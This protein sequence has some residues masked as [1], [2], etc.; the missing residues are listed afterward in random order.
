ME[1]LYANIPVRHLDLT[2]NIKS[3]YMKLIS[4]ITE[5]AIISTSIR[6][7][8]YNQT[9]LKPKESILNSGNSD[10]ILE[11][12]KRVLGQKEANSLM[13]FNCEIKEDLKIAGF[14]L[15][16]IN[17]GSVNETAWLKKNITFFYVNK[18]PIDPNKKIMYLFGEFYRQYNNNSK[19]IA[20]LNFIIDS[21]AVDNNLSP[22]KRE[23]C[24]ENEKE[25]IEM[26][27]KRLYESHEINKAFPKTINTQEIDFSHNKNRTKKKTEEENNIANIQ[28]NREESD[29]ITKRIKSTYDEK[30]ITFKK[31]NLNENYSESRVANSFTM[32][33]Y[34]SNVPTNIKSETK[35]ISEANKRFQIRTFEP[36]K[37]L[38]SISGKDIDDD[39]ARNF[40]NEGSMIK[41]KVT[42][43][44]PEKS[45]IFNAN[46]NKKIEIPIYRIG[47]PPEK[48]SN[49]IIINS[50]IEVNNKFETPQNAIIIDKGFKSTADNKF[51]LIEEN[52]EEIENISNPLTN[53]S[54]N[55]PNFEKTFQNFDEEKNFNT[56]PNF[57]KKEF[58]NFEIIGQFNLGFIITYLPQKR[59]IFIIDQHASDEKRNYE[60]MIKSY[61][62]ENQLLFN[63]IVIS[64]L[65]DLERNTIKEN[66]EI[67]FKNGFN[68]NFTDKNEQVIIKTLPCFKNIQFDLNDFHEILSHLTNNADDSFFRPN[69]FK[70]TIA[71]KA[72]RKAIKVGD[73][74]NF[75]QMKEIV[76]NMETLQSPWNCPHGR[77]T[78]V[79]TQDLTTILQKI[80][81]K[82]PERKIFNSKLICD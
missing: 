53:I 36:K 4:L 65:S 21:K 25:I 2:K 44:E 15:K 11:R 46:N 13:E 79:K 3:H 5:Y 51:E 68:I 19:F 67:F 34:I 33:K 77:P 75:E 43:F 17:S 71:Y 55:Q 29:F 8:L 27:K 60:T 22:D 47:N 72:C 48:E 18:R 58:R 64:D 12:I 45:E 74:L 16:N 76:K 40:E 70:T 69:K 1:K 42:V 57:E 38:P 50:Q 24:F 81:I 52:F 56:I 62:F 32:N 14:I 30:I 7:S 23:V 41:F 35:E 59:Q 28:R 9:K 37:S 66:Q 54:I 63:P 39:D 78:M 61:K 82:K 10:D 20:I 26:L 6:I 80:S 31:N 73:E 49:E